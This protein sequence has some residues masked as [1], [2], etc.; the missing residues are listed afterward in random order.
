MCVC[1]AVLLSALAMAVVPS[2][3]S[4]TSPVL[5]FVPSDGSFP[6]HF[7]AEGGEVTAAMTGFDTVVHCTGSEG[8]GEITGP[9]STI[10]NYFFT[11]CKTQGGSAGGAKCK[12]ENA[13]EEEITSGSIEAD[14]VFINQATHEVGMVLNPHGG[15]Y[16]EF[17]CGGES[18]KAIGSFL[19]PVGPI[20]KVSSSF[21][22]TLSR[23]SDEQTPTEYETM[24]G[25]KLQAIPTGEREGH[26]A[27]NTG[28]ELSFTVLTSASLEIKAVNTAEVEAKRRTEEEAAA[29][30]KRQ[31][32]EAAAKK[33]QE[34]EA[35]KKRQEEEAAAK[36]RAEQRAK[37]LKHCRR[38]KSKHKRIQCEKRVK[39][40]YGAPG[41]PVNTARRAGRRSQ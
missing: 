31:E 24:S 26:P 33:R 30:K 41:S 8:E 39:K 21:T 28:V 27:A 15:V 2:S 36:K 5:E 10:S 13:N 9:R 6:I 23:L 40:K 32:E 37:A 7:E 34:E 20:N 18:V 12:T 35:A 3:A 17:E 25:E 38:A 4:A 1:T 11:G 19:S 29:K 14:L 22:A 16:L